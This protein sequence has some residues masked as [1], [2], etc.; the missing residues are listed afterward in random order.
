[1]KK[2]FGLLIALMIG[3]QTMAFVLPEPVSAEVYTNQA[4]ELMT[5]GNQL[6]YKDEPETVVRLTGMNIPGGEWTGTPAVEQLARSAKEA[7]YRWNTN[8]IRL[9]VSVEGWYGEYD[10]V[11]DGGNG[12]REY[13]DSIIQMVAAEGRYVVLDLH[14]YTSF[15]NQ[16]YLDFWRE[17]AV[18]YANHPAVLFGILNEPHSTTW[19]V[20]RNGNGSNITGHQ[21]VVEMIRDLGAKNIIVAGGLDWAYNLTGIVNGYALIDQGSNGDTSKTGNGIMYDTHI[22][23]WKGRTSNWD[24]AVGEV[25][26][27]YPILVGE[28]G[29]DPATNESVGGKVY[30][31]GSDMYHDKWMPELFAWM[32]DEETYGNLANWTGWCF[33]PNSSPRILADPDRFKNDDYDYPP[34][35]YCG[36]YVKEELE[37]DVGTNISSLAKVTTSGENN[38]PGEYLVDGNEDTVWSNSTS[39]EKEILLDFEGIATINRWRLK[40]IEVTGSDK[41]YNVSDFRIETSV[42]GREWAVLDEITNN[43]GGYLERQV[44]PTPARYV[45]FVITKG[46][47]MDDIAR[48]CDIDLFSNEKIQPVGGDEPFTDGSGRVDDQMTTFVSQDFEEATVDNQVIHALNK[49]TGQDLPWTTSSDG[50][51]EIAAGDQVNQSSY[52]AGN[53][54]GSAQ[55]TLSL[56]EEVRNQDALVIFDLRIKRTAL[57]GN[58]TSL[59]LKDKNDREVYT[60]TYPVGSIPILTANRTYG[61]DTS[62][63]ALTEITY[64]Y[65]NSWLYVRTIFNQK[66]EQFEMYVGNNLYTMTPLLGENASFGYQNAAATGIAQISIG[67]CL[68]IDDL[69]LYTANTK[70]MSEDDFIS[71]NVGNGIVT[72]LYA[73]Q[74]FQEASLTTDTIPKIQV[75]DKAVSKT[76]TWT[77][78]TNTISSP[79]YYMIKTDGENAYLGGTRKGQMPISFRLEEAATDGGNLLYFDAKIKRESLVDDDVSLILK[80]DTGKEIIEIKYPRS[81]IPQVLADQTYGN[82]TGSAADTSICYPFTDEWVYLR[83]ML[84]FQQKTVRIYQGPDENQLTEIDGNTNVMGFKNADAENLTEVYIGSKGALNIDDLKIRAGIPYDNGDTTALQIN[85]IFYGESANA[86]VQV[87]KDADAQIDGTLYIALYTGQRMAYIHKEDIHIDSG[88]ALHEIQISLGSIPEENYTVK[89]FLWDADMH[90]LADT[91][92]YE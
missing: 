19:D 78:G 70:A 31:P 80:D 59:I 79:Q 60:L 77:H 72:K 62:N 33:H 41:A 40:C 57:N 65:T 30:P 55:I 45:R 43:Q 82:N 52:I 32:N 15:N 1:M 48:I 85:S 73:L 39:G 71:G 89:A 29:W 27:Q 26:K 68:C 35:D 86:E 16:K 51:Y 90:P 17:A 75:F 38:P 58:D 28:S 81:S 4:R 6:V 10:Y 21:Q 76:V 2:L 34:T 22:Y 7:M 3:F 54:D 64:P 63:T 14:H 37:K 9:P 66:M 69:N 87:I 84:D 13:I 74:D 47:T 24:N 20:W 44:K 83:I 36:V 91:A 67:G 18:K 42:N 92:I 5:S 88:I 49:A 25:R 11:S 61:T 12:Y 56:P 46:S 8:L 53:G 23:P 50:V